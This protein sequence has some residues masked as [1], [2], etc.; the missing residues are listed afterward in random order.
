MGSFT[1][2]KSAAISIRSGLGKRPQTMRR[3]PEDGRS[4][5]SPAHVSYLRTYRMLRLVEEQAR[6]Q[7]FPIDAAPA[8]TLYRAGRTLDMVLR[9]P[10]QSHHA[11]SEYTGL[12]CAELGFRSFRLFCLTYFVQHTT[13]AGLRPESRTGASE[14]V[15]VIVPKS[16]AHLHG[17]ADR[18]Y[19]IGCMR[20][21]RRRCCG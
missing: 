6:N 5:G 13:G 21:R 10:G 1:W 19:P 17:I 9:G 3:L 16:S 12:A 2:R 7:A 14:T 15:I 11:R 18:N 20:Y 4:M 8:H